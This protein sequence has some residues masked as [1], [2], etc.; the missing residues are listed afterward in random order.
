MNFTV[1]DNFLRVAKFKK[2]ENIKFS[3]IFLSH[4]LV[5]YF[6]NWLIYKIKLKILN[7]KF[8]DGIQNTISNDQM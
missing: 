4:L 3:K 2:I 6:G 7:C 1:F 8:S 5:N